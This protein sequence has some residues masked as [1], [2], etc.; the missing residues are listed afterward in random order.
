MRVPGSVGACMRVCACSLAYSACN[1]YAPYCDIIYGS[2][3]FITFFDIMSLVVR[4]K[5]KIIEHK[6]RV[7]ILSA[8]FV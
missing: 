8:N 7:L 1:L 4:F 5:K 6:I 2:S 3:G